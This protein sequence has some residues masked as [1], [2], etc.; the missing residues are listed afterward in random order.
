MT[1][2]QI[3]PTVEELELAIRDESIEL[4]CV[5]HPRDVSHCNAVIYALT[6]ALE[7]AKGDKCVVPR[8][9]TEAMIHAGRDCKFNGVK[10]TN[11]K[12]VFKAMIAVAEGEK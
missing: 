12:D 8:E 6:Q 10:S 1:P 7:I 3:P 2:E 5:T 9:P 4:R 11:P